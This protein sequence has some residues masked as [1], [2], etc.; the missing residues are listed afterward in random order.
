MTL[1]ARSQAPTPA[2]RTGQQPAALDQGRAPAPPPI[3]PATP[4]EH[5]Q[6]VASEQQQHEGGKVNYEAMIAYGTVALALFTF[7]LFLYTSRLWRATVDLGKDAKRTAD[8]QAAETAASLAIARDAADAATRS[9]KAAQNGVETSERALVGTQ[10]AFVFCQGFSAAANRFGKAVKEYVF[11]V[12]FQNVGVT[13]ATDMRQTFAIKFLPFA[14]SAAPHF[15]PDKMSDAATVLGPHTKAQSPFF[16]VPL[17]TMMQIWRRELRG[18]V[19][20]RIEYRDVLNPQV[21]HHHEQCARILLLRD[22]SQVSDA[23]ATNLS[24]VQFEITGPQNTTS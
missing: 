15:V 12:P 23:D 9:A 24:L 19:W 8:R 3:I 21:L 22:P 18:F 1:F 16:P 7:L 4:A 11:W 14:E 13:P 20:C 5:S 6:T 10:R 17:G 2:K